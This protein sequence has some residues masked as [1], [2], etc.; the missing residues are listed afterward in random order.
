[1]AIRYLP[2]S[3]V[4]TWALFFV[5]A[6][7]AIN[8]LEACIR[9]FQVGA[10][11]TDGHGRRCVHGV[12]LVELHERHRRS[13][14]L[15]HHPRILHQEGRLSP[16]RAQWCDNTRVIKTYRDEAVVLRTHKL[17]EADRI[18]WLLTA[19]HGIVRAIAKGVRRTNS[20]FG[21]HV[22]PFNVIDVQLHV[23]RSLDTITQVSLISSH[24]QALAA[25]FDLYAR[26]CV[27]VETAERLTSDSD[28]GAHSQYLLLV[29]ALHAL[30]N[31]RH[32]PT[33]TVTSYIL[34]A[35]AIAG[36]AP[37]CFDCAVCGAP[38]PHRAFSISE[39][40][41][42]CDECRRA[43]AAAPAQATMTLMG[44]LLSGD[45]AGADTSDD[46]ARQE[47]AGLVSAYA[48]WH[49]E[50]R[51]KSLRVLERSRR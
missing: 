24:G 44:D 49:L 38:G 1:M 12:G 18:I 27:M 40:G 33:L 48:Q 41:V 15:L 34:R 51:I 9:D 32:D 37:S 25:D 13:A 17:A 39:G 42:V 26:A 47:A 2:K 8:I 6:I 21:F 4:N 28:E 36:W 31:H 30:A 14:H 19:E 43:G 20:K 16:L 22:E 10:M 46:Y 11:G 5:P 7:L 29:G 35:L 3:A 50:R 45:W 23:G